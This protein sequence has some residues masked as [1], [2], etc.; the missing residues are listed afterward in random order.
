MKTNINF[1]SGGKV[2]IT[3]SF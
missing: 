2:K 3:T 1:E